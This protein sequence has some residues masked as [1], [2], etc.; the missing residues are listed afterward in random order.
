[1]IIGTVGLIILLV[2][3]FDSSNPD[4]ALSGLFLLFIGVPILTAVAGAVWWMRSREK[5]IRRRI[6]AGAMMLP[7]AVVA[8]IGIS[9]GLDSVRGERVRQYTVHTHV[10][11][12]HVGEYTEAQRYFLRPDGKLGVDY[13]L[14]FITRLTIED[15]HSQRQFENLFD[16]ELPESDFESCFFRVLPGQEYAGWRDTL[17]TERIDPHTINVYRVNRVQG[18]P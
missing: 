16:V 6:I 15:E 12:V 4:S 3:M 5:N 1:M 17:Q 13:N 10:M 11:T 9:S 14:L 2:A 7:L 8:F 18:R